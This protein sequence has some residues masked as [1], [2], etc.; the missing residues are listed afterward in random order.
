ML[1]W[2]MCH[3]GSQF[4]NGSSSSHTLSGFSTLGVNRRWI[5]WHPYVSI[6]M[7]VL[8]HLWECVMFRNL[9]MEWFQPS[10]EVS[11][12]LCIFSFGITSSIFW[13]AGHRS[14]QN[15][16]LVVPCWIEVLWLL[17]ISSM[18]EDVL[19]QCLIIK[20][21]ISD[22]SVDWVLKGWPLLQ[23]TL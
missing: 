12:V 13:W 4:K 23:L 14:V 11:D 16:I 15:L 7:S 1:K 17:T 19:H 2:I 21:L 20:V 22:I 18:L 3:R 10:I 9:G 6:N 8:L 5:C